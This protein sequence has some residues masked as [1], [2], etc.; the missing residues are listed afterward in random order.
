MRG[1]A[2]GHRVVLC[3]GPF[4]LRQEPSAVIPRAGIC[5][6]GAGS[7]GVPTANEYADQVGAG[8]SALACHD[9]RAQI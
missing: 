2:Y 8:L 6:G 9:R 5:A 4:D 1:S 3:R 7:T